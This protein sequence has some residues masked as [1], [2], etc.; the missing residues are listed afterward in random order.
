MQKRNFVCVYST[1]HRFLREH[2]HDPFLTGRHRPRFRRGCCVRH[3]GYVYRNI[4]LAGVGTAARCNAETVVRPRRLDSPSAPTASARLL[5]NQEEI[6][7]AIAPY[8][9]AA[10]GSQLTNLLKQH[11]LIAVDLVSAAKAGDQAKVADADR[12]WH[13]NANDIATFL[14]GANPNWPKATVLAMLNQ[15][16]ALTTQ[17]ATARIQGRWADDASAFDSIFNQILGMADALSDGIVKQ[18]PNR[19]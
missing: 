4:T 1:A 5:R 12:R 19:F 13:A 14:S 18:F 2:C 10:A 16:L 15:H 6:G 8:Y 11:I 9:G 7:N 3:S 17:E